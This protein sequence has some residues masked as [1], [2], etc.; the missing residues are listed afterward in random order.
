MSKTV[1]PQFVEA[2]QRKK[3]AVLIDPDQLRLQHLDQIVGVLQETKVDFVMVGGSLILEDRLDYCLDILKKETTCPLVLFPGSALQISSK[4][5]A[6]LFLS[7]IS[8]RNPEYLIGQHVVAAPYLKASGIEVISTG[9]MLVDG[10]VQTTASYMSN[11]MPIPRDKSEIAVCTALAGEMLGLKV[12]YLDAGSGAQKAVPVEM[13]AAVASQVDVPIIV[14]GGI[15]SPEKAVDQ[16]RAG[17]DILMVGT[18]IEREPTLL[19]ELS[20][21]I[22]SVNRET[23]P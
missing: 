17:A 10:G 12:L 20:W 1:F 6:I 15:R 22:Q 11:A 18:G 3:L 7:L 16:L 23:N 8:G 19:K 13:T 4:A 5:D 14:G 9:Y 2:K 21:A